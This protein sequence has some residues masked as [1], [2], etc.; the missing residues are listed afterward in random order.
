MEG[1]PGKNPALMEDLA[2]ARISV[3]QTA[4]RVIHSVLSEDTGRNHN[5]QIVR[6]IAEHELANILDIRRLDHNSFSAK[7]EN[8]YNLALEI[9]NIWIEN[10]TQLRFN[11][12]GSYT[13]EYWEHI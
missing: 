2:T 9:T 11:S 13:R 7:M 10:Y 12:L 3:A 5:L 8:R 4:Q 6:S 1:K